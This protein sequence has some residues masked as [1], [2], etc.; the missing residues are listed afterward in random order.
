MCAGGDVCLRTPHRCE[1]TPCGFLLSA[2]WHHVD[3]VTAQPALS[4]IVRIAFSHRAGS[5]S[6]STGRLLISSV[7]LFPHRH[8]APAAH[9]FHF[10]GISA[11]PHDVIMRSCTNARSQACCMKIPGS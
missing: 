7:C 1:D 4:P 8:S 5:A 11:S 3:N 10:L 6:Y 2:G 9:A